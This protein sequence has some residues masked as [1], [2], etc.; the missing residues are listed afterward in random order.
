ML[1]YGETSGDMKWSY[2]ILGKEN[3]FLTSSDS[4]TQY[5]RGDLERKCF[6]NQE[7]V[8]IISLYVSSLVEKVG[9]Y[10]ALA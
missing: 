8:I 10:P 5:F 1:A 3:Y 6:S 7:D 2:K 4:S 9:G